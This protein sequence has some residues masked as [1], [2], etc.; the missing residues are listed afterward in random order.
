MHVILLKSNIITY[1]YIFNLAQLRAIQLG[2][3]LMQTLCGKG[4]GHQEMA[5][6]CNLYAAHS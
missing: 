6:V 2:S 1:K 5:Q 3:T 4:A